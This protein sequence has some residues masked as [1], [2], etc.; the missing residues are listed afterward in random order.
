MDFS[1]PSTTSL[2]PPTPDV[3]G[4]HGLIAALMTRMLF[5]AAT[6]PCSSPESERTTNAEGESRNAQQKPR[7][8]KCLVPTESQRNGGVGNPVTRAA[9]FKR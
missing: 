7:Q 5:P 1:M 8:A 4:A 3:E 2:A 9:H 6:I